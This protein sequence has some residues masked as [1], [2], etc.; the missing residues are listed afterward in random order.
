MDGFKRQIQVARIVEA[1]FRNLLQ[2]PVAVERQQSFCG[3][4]SKRDRFFFKKAAKA[5][6][7]LGFPHRGPWLIG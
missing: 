2:L 1:D 3:G 7:H 5:K 4:R 6:A